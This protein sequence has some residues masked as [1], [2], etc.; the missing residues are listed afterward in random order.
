MA[1]VAAPVAAQVPPRAAEIPGY[2]GIHATIT[3]LIK[4]SANT[5]ALEHDHYDAVTIAAVTNDKETLRLL[6]SLGVSAKLITSRYD[7]TVPIAAAYLGRDGVVRQWIQADAP[8][9]QVNNLHSPALIES[10]VLGDGGP[11]HPHTL[12][13][14]L[15]A[16]AGTRIT[17]C[18][19]LTPLQLA[20]TRGYEAMVKALL[21][22]GAR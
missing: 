19:G 11:R 13:A 3:V 1:Y 20:R 16:D 4:A 10:I 17:D 15:K 7:G 21:A 5:T 22:A 2:T 9:D 8:L 12:Q 6:L 14:L 18:G